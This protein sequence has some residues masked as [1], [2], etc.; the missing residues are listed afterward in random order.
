MLAT[1]LLP[2]VK[3]PAEYNAPDVLS[4]VAE[5]FMLIKHPATVPAPVNVKPAAAVV[6][7]VVVLDGVVPLDVAALNVTVGREPE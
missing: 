5:P 4:I 7:F 3:L 6:F 1:V 2:P